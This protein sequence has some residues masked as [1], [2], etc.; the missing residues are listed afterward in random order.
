MKTYQLKPFTTAHK[1]TVIER[2]PSLLRRLGVL[3]RLHPDAA[4]DIREMAAI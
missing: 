1:V 3:E 4:F 2:M